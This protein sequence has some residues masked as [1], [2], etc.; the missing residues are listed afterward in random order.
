MARGARF[1]FICMFVVIEGCDGTG[2]TTLAAALA[3]RLADKN[4]LCIRFPDRS[5][6]TGQTID[7]YLRGE[8]PGMTAETIHLLMSANRW[9]R[10]SAITEALIADRPVICDRYSYSG[11][12][13]SSA[14]GLEL[15][16][17]LAAD[18]GLPEPSLILYLDTSRPRMSGDEIY[19][20]E[21][22]QKRVRAAYHIVRK[23]D[24]RWV[25]LDA[26]LSRKEL[27]EAALSAIERY[28]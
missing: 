22:F 17:C 28:A 4:P 5:T 9:E 2:K 15:A 1:S 10:A 18:R 19:E 24:K 3:K 8:T 25:T 14:K 26:D 16:W 6:P 11:A 7:A 23:R 12:A 20:R 21:A 13:Y 27:L